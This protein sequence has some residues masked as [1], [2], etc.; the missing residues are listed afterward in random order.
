MA[1]SVIWSLRALQDRK[2]ILAYWLQHNQSN[3]YSLKL[4]K[5]FRDAVGLIKRYPQIGKPTDDK[6]ARIKVVRDYLIIYE[7]HDNSIIILTIW[8]SRQDPEKLSIANK[9]T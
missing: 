1:K 2:K 6:K 8:D 9:L 7:L 5:L 4:D 3:S